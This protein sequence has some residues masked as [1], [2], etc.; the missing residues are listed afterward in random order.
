MPA[1][2]YACKLGFRYADV[3]HGFLRHFVI[4]ERENLILHRAVIDSRIEQSLKVAHA[5]VDCRV[6]ITAFTHEVL[7]LLQLCR[8]ETLQGYVLAKTLQGI[9]QGII[10][11]LCVRIAFLFFLGARCIAWHRLLGSWIS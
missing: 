7:K 10:H 2:R 8:A 9:F 1:L 6:G 4:T 3:A 5:D 11:I